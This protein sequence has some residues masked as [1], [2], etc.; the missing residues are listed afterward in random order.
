MAA[1]QLSF[2]NTAVLLGIWV[3]VVAACRLALWISGVA[4][5]IK[6]ILAYA[7]A[8][9]VPDDAAITGA[10]GVSIVTGFGAAGRIEL[11]SANILNGIYSTAG[12]S[13]SLRDT[14]VVLCS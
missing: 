5:R 6:H 7:V 3:A 4:A 2:K 8:I 13:T 9:S 14:L 11:R 10:V 12:A 1:A